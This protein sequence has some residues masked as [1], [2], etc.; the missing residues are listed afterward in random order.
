MSLP[1]ARRRSG[2]DAALYSSAARVD[3]ALT[4]PRLVS[5]A[6][7]ATAVPLVCV[8]AYYQKRGSGLT[9]ADYNALAFLGPLVVVAFLLVGRLIVIARVAQQRAGELGHQA[10]ALAE[11]VEA[12]EA[13]R[14]Q[15][16]YRARHD[17]LTGL[18]NRMVFA[19]RL[20]WALS[21]RTGSQRHALI[22]LDLR[23]VQRR[24]RRLWAPGGRRGTDRDGPPS[25]VGGAAGRDGGA[26]GR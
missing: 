25:P 14:R 17:P 1:S 7:L 15:L 26:D 4:V 8:I 2:P 6:V 19:E 3:T 10:R 13:L 21:R 16:I 20:D 9:W 22:L 24:Q 18:P 5:L 11:A 23:R 12:Q